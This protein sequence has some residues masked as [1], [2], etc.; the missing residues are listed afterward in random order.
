MNGLIPEEVLKQT[1]M[2]IK[3]VGGKLPP[4]GLRPVKL[5][6]KDIQ[7]MVGR[8]NF[9]VTARVSRAGAYLMRP[10]FDWIRPEMFEKL[11]TQR[12]AG[13]TLKKACRQTQCLA[14]KYHP[15]VITA[16]PKD[17][18]QCYLATDASTD[19]SPNGLPMIGGI[20]ITAKGET[21]YFS[22]EVPDKT[23][24][25]ELEALAVYEA[26][27][28]LEAQL[29]GTHTVLLVDNTVLLYGLV[30]GSSK[31]EKVAT[32][33]GQI[34]MRKEDISCRTFVEFIKSE[35]NPGDAFTRW[36]LLQQMIQ[37][38]K[39][40]KI[41]YEP[42]SPPVYDGTDF[43]AQ[44]D[45]LEEQVKDWQSHPELFHRARE[46]WVTPEKGEGEPHWEWQVV[47]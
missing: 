2:Q 45:K 21:L 43:A 36:E 8:C 29:M 28:A 1:K 7:R 14:M 15:H 34:N 9:V 46:V 18:E 33:L 32:M 47:H 35:F 24:I 30:K 12:A 31:S 44:A 40:K 5:T 38:T 6:V 41:D 3:K 11:S 4:V 39:A 22:R 42:P 13:R 17:Y 19:G 26:T 23:D 20:I 10:A 37:I 16:N 25:A 27:F